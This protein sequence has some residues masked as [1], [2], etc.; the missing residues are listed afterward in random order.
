M[1]CFVGLIFLYSYGKY[2]ILIKNTYDFLQD[3]SGLYEE[4]NSKWY[5]YGNAIDGG[6]VFGE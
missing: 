2:G 1:I 6:K 4:I 3:R 5:R